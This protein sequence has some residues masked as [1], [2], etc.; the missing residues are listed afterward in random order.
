MT[1]IT[2]GNQ[3]TP[4]QDLSGISILPHESRTFDPDIVAHTVISN[5]D[6]PVTKLSS[7]A[8]RQ[9]L[10]IAAHTIISN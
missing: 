7:E 6:G 8:I 10:D 1:N 2:S 4:P 3:R 5:Q 9:Q